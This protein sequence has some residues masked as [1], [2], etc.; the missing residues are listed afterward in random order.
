MTEL[1]ET[2]N[3]QEEEKDISNKD[4][5]NLIKTVISS[6]NEIKKQNDEIKNE[7]HNI[8]ADLNDEI[9]ELKKENVVLKESVKVLEERLLVNERKHKKFNLII[10]G[11]KEEEDEL[12]DIECFLD[13]INNKCK[14]ECKFH[15]LRDWYRIGSKNQESEKPRPIVVELLYY[16]Q[17]E[18]ILEK[19]SNLK[20]S[21]IYIS[22][23]FIKEDY[24]SRKI[25]YSNLKIA[26]TNDPEA[27][28]TKNKL[29][30]NGTSYTA[31]ELEDYS[32]EISK[33]SR[34]HHIDPKK[35]PKPQD[36]EQIQQ[37][38][39]YVKRKDPPNNSLE[40]P[41]KR[42]TRQFSNSSKHKFKYPYLF[43][44]YHI[45]FIVLLH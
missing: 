9:E 16:K 25:L 7:I 28:I 21:G 4:L 44:M 22:K 2:S 40:L 12:R 38:T 41:P 1:L 14:V 17:K 30:V 26:R 6:N 42:I 27:K 39:S 3:F 36:K 15:D 18:S 20:G 43:F 37:T 32:S 33:N 35:H 13:I 29:I 45:D 8:R 24:I 11:M 31:E 34:H 19:A 23:D 5:F 10:Y